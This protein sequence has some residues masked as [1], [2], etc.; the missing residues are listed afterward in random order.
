MGDHIFPDYGLALLK[1]K[2]EQPVELNPLLVEDV[3]R[4]DGDTYTMS[5]KI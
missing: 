3:G 1:A 2:V 4:I 5:G